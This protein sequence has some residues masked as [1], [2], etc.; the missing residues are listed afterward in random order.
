MATHRTDKASSTTAVGQALAARGWKLFGFHEDRSDSMFRCRAIASDYYH[1]A[2][3]DGV[4]VLGDVVAC[5]NVNGWHVDQS[6]KDPEIAVRTPGGP[7]TRCDGKRSDPRTWRGGDPADAWTLAEA[8]A[9]PA[10]Y[11]RETDEPGTCAFLRDVVS[12]IG[13]FGQ[14]WGRGFPDGDEFPDE[15]RNRKRCSRCAGSG[16]ETVVSKRPSGNP[17]PTFQA[18]PKGCTW[19]LE[20]GGRIFAKGTGVFTC[21]KREKAEQL[22]A[23]LTARATSA[24]AA[25][26][27]PGPV[28]EVEVR[29]G[30][31]PEFVEVH[32]PAKPGPE[33]LDELRA[34]GFRWAMRARCW[35]GPAV[36]LPARYH[37]RSAPSRQ[38]G[39]GTIVQAG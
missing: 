17:W 35:Y 8:K 28:G 16:T 31:R 12:P 25:R 14:G 1:P 5:V 36:A 30:L 7:C 32:F 21:T 10:R 19:H 34:A 11:H 13:W 2:S 33:V 24:P 37:G 20:R 18:N 6:G 3:W 38:E 39:A 4:A 29:P 26:V 9:D 23:D 15:V 27:A 22:A